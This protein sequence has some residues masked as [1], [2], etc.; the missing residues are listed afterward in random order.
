MIESRQIHGWFALDKPA[1]ITSAKAMERV[2]RALRAEKAGHGGT[3]DPMATGVLPIAFGEATKTVDY[4]MS[5]RKTY[6]FRITWGESRDTD[7]A[8]GKVTA[9]SNVR[10]T[11]EEIKAALG[12]FTG[13]IEQ[14]PP[15]YSAISVNGQR[16]YEAARAGQALE[17]KPRKVMVYR[18]NLIAANGND[19]A[20]FEVECGKGT[21]VRSLARDLALRLGTLGYVSVLRRIANGAFTLERAVTLEQIEKD[22]SAAVMPKLVSIPEAMKDMGQVKIT[23]E[24]AAKLR[25]GQRVALSAAM[26]DGHLLA[27]CENKPVAIAV[28][29]GHVLQ[30]VRVFKE[31]I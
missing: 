21:Y 23:A 4:V 27:I 10:P 13:E 8:E 9:A 28:M 20:D 7:D 11:L 16:A 24:Q 29:E 2:R 5:G 6:Q 30:P 1:G 22:S 12:E 19:Y 31:G 14:V 26:K 25:Q 18:L 17:L 15:A 3:L